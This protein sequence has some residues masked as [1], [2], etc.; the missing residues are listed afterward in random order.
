MPPME[1]GRELFLQIFAAIHRAN[2]DDVGYSPQYCLNPL[3]MLSSNI[4]EAR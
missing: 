1:D 4:P 2:A 3:V